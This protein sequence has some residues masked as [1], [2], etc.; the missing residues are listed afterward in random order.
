MSRHA[1]PDV[2]RGTNDLAPLE[3][4]TWNTIYMNRNDLDDEATASD[5]HL[6]TR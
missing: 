5:S 1:S 4:F 2:P 3:C 6:L